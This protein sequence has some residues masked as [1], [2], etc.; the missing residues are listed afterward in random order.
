MRIEI[1]ERGEYLKVKLFVV[2]SILMS[3]CGKQ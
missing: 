3:I 1:D 2:G